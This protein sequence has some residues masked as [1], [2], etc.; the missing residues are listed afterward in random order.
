MR[1]GSQG[2]GW[3]KALALPRKRKHLELTAGH[4]T[5]ETQ[6][7]IPSSST[8]DSS[9]RL[10]SSKPNAHS[11]SSW[12]SPL[13]HF[14]KAIF[15]NWDK[16]LQDK[17]FKLQHYGNEFELNASAEGGCALCTQFRSRQPLKWEKFE[18]MMG[19]PLKKHNSHSQENKRTIERLKNI[20]TVKSRYS[21]VI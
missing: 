17:E 10:M 21:P 14:C 3:R 15:K 7:G 9:H 20:Y 6:T 12:V 11:A 4:E 5:F 13:C 2:S 18:G 1:E 19:L 8:Q 16:F